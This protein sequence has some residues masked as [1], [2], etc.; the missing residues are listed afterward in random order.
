MSAPP[1]FVQQPPRTAGDSTPGG[2]EPEFVGRVAVELR[3]ARRLRRA[4]LL[5][6]SRVT[7]ATPR[8]S[9]PAPARVR[10]SVGRLPNRWECR[11]VAWRA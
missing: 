6:S 8:R 11:A 7:S 1:E 3:V 4:D 9:R 5:S 10:C 2:A